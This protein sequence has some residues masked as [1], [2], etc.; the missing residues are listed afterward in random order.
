MSYRC[1]T[2]RPGSWADCTHLSVPASVSFVRGTGRVG[3][4]NSACRSE[5]IGDEMDQTTSAWG[6]LAGLPTRS[7]NAG[8]VAGNKSHE[9]WVKVRLCHGLGRSYLLPEVLIGFGGAKFFMPS[10]FGPPNLQFNIS[11]GTTG[12]FIKYHAVSFS[13]DVASPRAAQ[14]VRVMVHFRSCDRVRVYDSG[15][16]LYRCTYSG[17]LDVPL[18]PSIAGSC[19]PLPNGDF[20]LRVFHHT[21]PETVEK[22]LESGELRSGAYNIAGT[23]KLQTVSHTYFTT[24]PTIKTE[25]DLRRIAMSSDA[26]ISYQTTSERLREEVLDLPVYVGVTDDRTAAMNF[27]VPCEMIAPAH[28]LFHAFV[29]PNPAYYEVVGPEIVRVAVPPGTNLPFEGSRLST[30][31]SGLKH[32]DHVVEG[33]ASTRI[34]LEAPM[35]EDTT[36]QIALLAELSEETNL[37]QFWQGH[38]NKN[39]FS[40]RSVVGRGVVAG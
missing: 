24:L 22:I 33:D 28:L 30:P 16:E 21:R 6:N 39:L 40:R 36:T 12:P 25:E 14:A 9:G 7:S 34:G 11:S 4:G 20:S 38:A 10:F 1:E 8:A 5:L 29:P 13:V 37:F 2:V 18:A 35:S 17:P 15:A 19:Y 27:D 3:N 23:G 26:Q 31:T 32:F